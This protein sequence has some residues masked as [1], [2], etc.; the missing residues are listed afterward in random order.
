MGFLCLFSFS[1]LGSLSTNDTYTCVVLC[2]LF[3]LA[4][5]NSDFPPAPSLMQKTE[6]NTHLQNA[7][8]LNSLPRWQKAKPRSLISSALYRKQPKCTYR[9]ANACSYIT[10][11]W[12]HTRASVGRRLLRS[13]LAS[14]LWLELHLLWP[15][16]NCPGLPHPAS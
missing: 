4:T 5:W 8:T 10:D 15:R 11:V 3:S 7:D 9:K 2:I 6:Q 1:Y 13:Q 14:P 12:T 16:C